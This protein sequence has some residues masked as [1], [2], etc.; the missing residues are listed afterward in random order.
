MAYFVKVSRK[1]ILRDGLSLLAC[2]VGLIWI[3]TGNTLDWLDGLLLILMYACY[4]I[5]LFGTMD[6]KEFTEHEDYDDEPEEKGRLKGL[7][8][9]NIRRL[10]MGD[11][12]INTGS[13]WC[14]FLLST[15]VIGGACY[16]LVESCYTLGEVLQIPTY[17]VAVILA[18]AATSV[19]DTIISIKDARNGNYDDAVANALGSNIFDICVC[20]GLPLL[21]YCLMTGDTITLS[22]ADTGSVAELRVLLLGLTGAV[23]LIMLFSSVLAGG[24]SILMFSLYISFVVYI[25]ARAYECPIAVSIGT[26]LQNFLKMLGG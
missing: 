24:A 20:L 12:Y 9:L 19:P 26:E 25:V 23:F 18:A 13:A 4:V 11:R 15:A 5:I 14:L 7:I 6:N 10:W 21:V 8:T 2:E 1:V 16:I 17:F 3:L 22:A